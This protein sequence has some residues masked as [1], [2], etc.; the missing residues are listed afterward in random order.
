MPDALA[1]RGG[2]LPASCPQGKTFP[3]SSL[4]PWRYGVATNSS[5]LARRGWR[6]GRERSAAASAAA[7]HRRNPRGPHNQCCR[8]KADLSKQPCPLLSTW[9]RRIR[10]RLHVPAAAGTRSTDALQP[11]LEAAT[12][13]PRC[14]AKR[15]CLGDNPKPSAAL[16]APNVLIDPA[17]SAWI[18]RAQRRCCRSANLPT[19]MPR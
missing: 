2:A 18:P 15:I 3:P 11:R 6:R 4:P 5:A 10:L 7:K 1:R 16:G 8:S 13:N 12:R 14:I 9:L 17:S 19:R